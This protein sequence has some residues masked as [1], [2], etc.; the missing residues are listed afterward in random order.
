[1]VL[2]YQSTV[3]FYATNEGMGEL[4]VDDLDLSVDTSADFRLISKDVEII[5]PGESAEL[6]VRYI[7]GE[8]GQDYG[9]LVL[10]SDDSE[11][12]E[13]TVD[14]EAFG[15]EPLVDVEPTILWYGLVAQDETATQSFEI[16]ARGTGSL[17]I[18]DLSFGEDEAEAFT[19]ELPSGVELPY[20]MASG[21]SLSVD[22]H[23]TAIDERSWDGSLVIQSN[24][25]T[26]PESSV[27]L[28]ANSEDDPTEND[29]PIVEILDPDYMAYFLEGDMVT[30]E[31][32]V[33]DSEGYLETIVG[34]LYA[35]STT[36]GSAMATS[37]GQMIFETS[38]L[39]PGDVTLTVRAFD[40][41]GAT[42]ED[43]AC[44][45]Q[46]ISTWHRPVP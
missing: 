8:V 46:S 36:V 29:S 39:P 26:T 27:Q 25:P 44:A 15:V 37:D 5:D 2:G 12:P 42:G 7:P 28:L 16:S 20:T 10:V 34:A 31:A 3:G 23:F 21:L 35:D 9:S 14:L 43:I 6:M 4:V 30:V 17:K 40:Q 22:V 45:A 41:E 18:T 1:V 24:D 13:A 32:Q 33:W 11:N 38:S 19:I